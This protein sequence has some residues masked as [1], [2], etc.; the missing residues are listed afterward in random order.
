[1]CALLAVLCLAGPVAAASP[2]FGTP[3]ASSK[4][5]TGITFTQ[6]YSGAT[7]TSASLLVR[8]PEDLGPTVIPLARVG[9]TSLTATLDTSGGG[10]YPN[11]PVTAHFEVVL[12]DGTTAAGP[13][14]KITYADDRFTW[15]VLPG[16]LVT[17][18]YIEA[19]ASAAFAQQ[20]LKW[21]DD[22]VTK[23]SAMFGVT[24]SKRIDYFIYPDQQTF[25]Q[26]LSQPLTA[27]G[28]TIGR[29]CFAIVG[30]SDSEYGAGVMP[31][32]VAHV[33]FG[34][35]V[36]NPYHSPPRWLNEGFAVYLSLGYDA[37][38]RRLVSMAVADGTLVPLRAL[39]DYFPYDENR[40]YLAYA[41]SVSAVD[42]MVRK[43]GQASIPKLMAAYAS[44]HSDDEA[45][46]TAFGV[47]MAGF[48]TAWL[49]EIG[50][51]AAKYGPQPAPTGPLPP[52]WNGS[53]TGPGAT[54]E[55]TGPTGTGSPSGQSGQST[56]QSGNTAAL[57]LAGLLA[58]AGLALL[59][60]SLVVLLSPRR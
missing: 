20:L 21:A 30:P 43:Y 50:V 13:D 28:V 7:I 29:S 14:I 18:H 46:Q 38:D 23:A 34:D 24:E 41:E 8:V 12:S 19:E 25:Q 16:K 40:V 27:G 60:G 5:G 15:K 4:F 48:D 17:L 22:G 47:D 42:F 57:L 2:T 49:A 32:E 59:G 10:M 55:P 54:A 35:A 1:M 26:G 9:S 39:T 58:V 45:F 52:G 44:G 56:S 31:H 51:T 36:S 37:Y 53:G 6:P 33:V 3:T 11:T